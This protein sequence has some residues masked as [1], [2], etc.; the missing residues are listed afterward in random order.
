[1]VKLG[2]QISARLENVEKM[3]V[4]GEDFRYFIKTLCCNCGEVSDK[5]QYVALN[6]T[7]DGRTGRSECHMKYKCKGCQREISLLIHEDS[8]KPY[9]YEE[10]KPEGFQTIAIFEGRGMEISDFEFRTGWNIK[11]LESSTKFENVD[12]TEREWVEFDEKLGE[13]IG[14]YELKHKFVKL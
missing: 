9:V 12:L 1:M 5:W 2:L 11:A 8:I 7:T 6:E 14:I 4:C 3:E 13:S 10:D